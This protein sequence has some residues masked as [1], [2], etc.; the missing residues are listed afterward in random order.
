MAIRPIGIPLFI[1][2]L[3]FL[4]FY[5]KKQEELQQKELI[6]TADIMVRDAISDLA[7]MSRTRKEG[8]EGKKEKEGKIVSRE[9]ISEEVRMYVWWRDEGKYSGPGK[10]DQKP[11][12]N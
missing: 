8:E 10:L 12:L 9:K 4:S 11:G 3:I 6:R 1:I 2:F 7:Y 5:S